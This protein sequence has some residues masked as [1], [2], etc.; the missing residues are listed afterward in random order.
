MCHTSRGKGH[1]SAPR[2]IT[3]RPGLARAP[4]QSGRVGHA[5]PNTPPPQPSSTRGPALPCTGTSVGRRPQVPAVLAPRPTAAAACAAGDPRGET[6]NACAGA[7]AGGVP[8]AS[9]AEPEQTRAQPAG[10]CC[11]HLRSLWLEVAKW[12]PVSMVRAAAVANY[13]L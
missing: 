12:L 13:C 4:V 10:C 6:H 5:L 2:E 3:C 7:T 8:G 11:E 9:M 1:D